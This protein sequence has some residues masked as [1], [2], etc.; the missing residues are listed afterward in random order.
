M[1]AE[2]GACNV[3]LLAILTIFFVFCGYADQSSSLS[4]TVDFSF[5]ASSFC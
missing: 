2:L 3:S 1:V 4:L 5:V